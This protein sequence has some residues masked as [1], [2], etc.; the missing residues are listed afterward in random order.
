MDTVPD[1]LRVADAEA[2]AV[3]APDA[4]GVFDAEAEF[5][6]AT[7][8]RTTAS[9]SSAALPPDPPRRARSIEEDTTT[10]SVAATSLEPDLSLG[11]R[12]AC[13]LIVGTDPRG[14]LVPPTENMSALLLAT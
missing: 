5:A 9:A 4:L 6:A 11:K 8:P 12:L 3:A 2:R 1:A 14:D 13:A 7:S 10:M